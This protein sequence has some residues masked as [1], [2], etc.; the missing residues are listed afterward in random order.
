MKPRRCAE[1]DLRRGKHGGAE[2]GGGSG[3]LHWELGR[4]AARKHPQKSD[5]AIVVVK[6]G[7][8]RG[9]KGL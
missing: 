5:E 4:S 2:R 8:A 9:A 1:V 3:K 7:N 6:R